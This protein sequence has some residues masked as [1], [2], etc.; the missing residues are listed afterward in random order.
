MLGFYSGITVPL[1][2]HRPPFVWHCIIL[3]HA[4]LVVPDPHCHMEYCIRAPLT[5][6]RGLHGASA[7]PS[8]IFLSAATSRAV[9]TDLPGF[10]TL[11]CNWLFLT[12]LQFAGKF[13]PKVLPRATWLTFLDL[14]WSTCVYVPELEFLTSQ[15]SNVVRRQSTHWKLEPKCNPIY[16]SIWKT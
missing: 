8:Y 7:A 3:Y 6:L 5:G 11:T 4:G 14:V 13:C 9:N 15:I 16:V 12:F 10:S 1:L 2:H